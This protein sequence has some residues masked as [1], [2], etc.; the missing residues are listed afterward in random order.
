MTFRAKTIIGIALIEIVLLMFLVFS[1]MTFL[2]DSNEQQLI[3]RANS[4]ASVFANASKDA[5]LSTDIA[6]LEDL[7]KQF[8]TLDG[9]EYVK[10]V[11]H[12]KV[13]ASAGEIDLLERD[14]FIDKGLD[15][16]NDGLFD[17]RVPIVN[18]GIEYGYIDM[19][20]STAAISSMLKNAQQSI[21]G[22][23]LIEV[24]L[25]A[26]FSLV[27]GTYLTRSL[28][29][30][31]AA[32]KTLS[33]RGPGYQL[34]DTSKDEFGNLSRAFDDMSR[35]LN[36]SYKDLKSARQEAEDACESK[37]RF[38][39]SMSHEIRTP[40]NGVLGILSLL[41][42]TPLNKQ[43]KHLLKTATTSGEF[44]LSVINDILDFT[45]MESNT[46]LLENKPFNFR[47]CVESVMDSFSSGAKH[48]DLILHCFIEGNVPS[49]VKGDVN[50]VRQI[51]HNLIGNAL[52]FT[53]EGS[54]TVKVEATTENNQCQLQCSVTDT[55]VGIKEQALSYLFE[56]FTMVD[57]TYSR[58]Q[59]GSGLG[60]A[61][62]KRL[63]ILMDG[64]IE[65]ASEYGQGSTFSFN[66]TLALSDELITKNAPS[67][68]VL[69]EH[70]LDARILVAE[71]NK[72]NQ[73]VIKNM[74]LNAGLDVDLADNG[75]MAI[76]ML[77]NY[78][79]DL[80]FMDIS[81][82]EMDGIEATQKIRAMDDDSI[83]NLPII[84]LTAHALTGDKENFIAAGMSDYLSKP[85]RLSQLIEKIHLFL[86][87][88]D[89]NLESEMAQQPPSTE[90]AVTQ[91]EA[92]SQVLIP[93][94]IEASVSEMDDLVDETILIQMIEDTSA[95][96]IP[97]LI[98]HYLEESKLRLGNINQAL[99]EQNLEQLEFETHTL[100]SSALAL[101]NRVL[102]EHAREIE[103]LCLESQ[104]AQAFER[105]SELQ[106]IAEKSL[107]AITARKELGFV[108]SSS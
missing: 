45:R 17:T 77:T 54:I 44:L 97:I 79:Y 9:I 105:V 53:S 82:P 12:D 60:L 55:G 78:S 74:F 23:A 3:E 6:T 96:V 2:S 40:M 37:G 14:M 94:N 38:L 99:K 93:T 67:K 101:G 42:E 24:I 76:D 10:I 66:I 103:R 39:A 7:V 51:L 62:C 31:T 15:G 13:L 71:D 95:D 25:V 91:S 16:V 107:N 86:S 69:S 26:L 75:K 58:S 20:F 19:G 61:I 29:R 92:H 33:E 108:E 106:E 56:E 43:Q 81:M 52:K 70:L 89:K 46:L 88:N 27:L 72:A 41:E 35:K 84:A 18:S 80:V 98:D 50:R 68:P 1:A 30:L 8:V 104:T 34:N 85:V 59:E 47:E 4:T 57:Q 5:V 73:L 100:G 36:T 22:I 32:T 48:K 11:R 28:I 21:V 90:F 64:N 102:S 83:K 49:M 87:D 65:V 63:C